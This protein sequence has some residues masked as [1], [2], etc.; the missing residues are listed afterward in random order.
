M[1]VSTAVRTVNVYLTSKVIRYLGDNAVEMEGADDLV[2]T[3]V[4]GSGGLFVELASKVGEE[5]SGVWVN[6]LG[7]EM[8]G[9]DDEGAD[10]ISEQAEAFE[11]KVNADLGAVDARIEQLEQE[12]K[13][14]QRVAGEHYST[15]IDNGLDDDT[16]SV[17]GPEPTD[18]ELM[19]SR[20]ETG[21][22]GDGK[23]L[24]G[25]SFSIKGYVHVSEVL[26]K[27]E[28]MEELYDQLKG[29]RSEHLQDGIEIETT[30]VKRIKK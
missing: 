8:H 26:G 29:Q 28:V 6:A 13:H 30:K 1:A 9:P 23:K 18:D 11:D 21:T 2:V 3:Q 19:G 7:V 4:D 14:W 24:K 12:I 15:L 20:G 22:R 25:Y 16:R 17:T 5:G 10:A 27:L